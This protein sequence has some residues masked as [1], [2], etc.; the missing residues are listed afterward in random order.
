MPGVPLVFIDHIMPD[1]RA[2]RS[3]SSFASVATLTASPA[4][5][6]SRREIAAIPGDVRTR[7]HTD[8]SYA[9]G[10][11]EGWTTGWIVSSCAGLLWIG[12]QH[13]LVQR[14]RPSVCTWA[15]TCCNA[16]GF[17]VTRIRRIL[18]ALRNWL[19]RVIG[20]QQDDDGPTPK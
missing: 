3:R 20:D 19:A 12:S 2:A 11:Y 16:S 17:E 14:H 7:P 8:R 10:A 5:A 6:A 9:K 1:L 4:P 18:V 15:R 13:A